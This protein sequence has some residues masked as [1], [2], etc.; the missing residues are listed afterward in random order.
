[1]LASS[2]AGIAFAFSGAEASDGGILD[3]G[4]SACLG[5]IATSDILEAF[6][7]GRAGADGV[8]ILYS[9]IAGL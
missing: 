8:Y 9:R 5:N 1:V 6:K 2:A 7:L 3:R 4:D